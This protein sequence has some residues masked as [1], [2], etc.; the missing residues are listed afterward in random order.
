[1]AEEQ[2]SKNQEVETPK[3]TEPAQEVQA[4][5]TAPKK[6][7]EQPDE[8]KAALAQKEHWREK[9]D[10]LQEQIKQMT[11]EEK[12]EEVNKE[13]SEDKESIFDLM[14]KISVLKD[15]SPEE[16]SFISD[17]AKGKGLQPEDVVSD[18]NIKIWVDAHRNK[19][20]GEE[21]TLE[22]SNRSV[23]EVK[24]EERISIEDDA[25]TAADKYLRAMERVKKGETIQRF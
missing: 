15:Y 4:E 13:E 8:L 20:A 3:E 11:T 2:T 17:Y 18:D 22:P 16:L 1:M 9:F 12:K 19:V 7:E 24:D 23:G 21:K 10:K 25:N 6:P 14:K 5:Q